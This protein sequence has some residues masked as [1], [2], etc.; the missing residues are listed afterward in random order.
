M[1]SRYEVEVTVVFAKNL[2]NVNWKHGDLRPYAVLWVDP[3]AK[4]STKVAVE[5]DDDGEDP[6]WDEKLTLHLPPGGTLDD[7]VLY[8][9]VVHAKNT[10]EDTKPLV[11]SARLPLREV[12]D[13]AGVGGRAVRTLK[14]KRPSG[15]P[16]GKLEVKVAVRE[17]ARYYDA[18][19]PGTGSHAPS[20]GYQYRDYGY[21][22]P[23]GAA[24]APDGYPSY[25]AAPPP[26]GYPYGAPPPPTAGY[27]Q[28]SS[29]GQQPYAVADQGQKKSKFGLGTGLAVGAAAGVLGGL[30]LAE[31]V[32]YVE[33]KIA[34]DAAEKVEEDLGYDDF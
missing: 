14:L 25:A 19:P 21:G 31:G 18:P 1:G 28:P 11:G 9:D 29:Y 27:G 26:S 13:E 34:D 17:P 3:A 15:R 32:D 6:F 30:A 33:D 24:P 8:V 4:C 22:A 2:K 10:E 7:A 5:P 23:Y 20:Y 16:Q 12:V